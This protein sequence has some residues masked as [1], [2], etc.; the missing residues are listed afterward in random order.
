MRTATATRAGTRWARRFTW[1]RQRWSA[2]HAGTGA[3]A[4]ALSKAGARTHSGT[5]TGA[6][7]AAGRRTGGVHGAAHAGLLRSTGATGASGTTRAGTEVAGTAGR[8]AIENGTA[9]LDAARRALRAGRRCSGHGGRRRSAVQG[10][11]AGLRHD[12]A[13]R[14]R[15]GG[16]GRRGRFN[17]RG[18]CLRHD[19]EILRR[20]GGDRGRGSSGLRRWWGCDHWRRRDHGLRRSGD[21]APFRRRRNGRAGHNGASGRT[22]GNGRRL[23]RSGNDGRTRRGRRS[24]ND[25]RSLA[26]LRNNHARSRPGFS[27]RRRGSSSCCRSS[28]P[29]NMRTLRRRSGSS[30]CCRTRR[31]GSPG[32]RWRSH[33]LVALL[34]NGFRHIAD[35]VNLGPVNLRLRFSFVPGGAHGDAAAFQDMGA[36]PLGF[37]RLN[38]AGVRLLFGHA[39]CGESI[40]NFFALHLQFTR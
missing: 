22:R 23:R 14:G 31:G 6:G 36:H 4:R 11:R 9:T 29:G 8:S 24:G 39:N 38:R 7:R 2:T 19:F 3:K 17:D 26:R 30:G 15:W 20:C 40:K 16:R 28:G 10:A 35:S 34:E 33:F 13:T 32:R 27:S 12:D 37:I 5:L 1:R 18:C 21:G 25:R